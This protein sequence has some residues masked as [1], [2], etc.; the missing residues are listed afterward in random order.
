MKDESPTEKEWSRWSTSFSS[1]PAL[2][3]WERETVDWSKAGRKRGRDRKR[4][5][6]NVCAYETFSVCPISH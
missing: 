1:V 5:E 4:K 2:T 3:H 6:V